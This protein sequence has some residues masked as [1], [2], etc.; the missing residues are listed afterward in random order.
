MVNR[1]STAG[2]LTVLAVIAAAVSTGDC[3]LLGSCPTEAGQTFCFSKSTLA[4]MAGDAG[5]APLD[6]GSVED[7]S[8]S[9]GGGTVACPSPSEIE[10]PPFSLLPKAESVTENVDECCYLYIHSTSCD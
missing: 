7:A 6:S 9:D 10:R 3:A 4:Q 2:I 1:A 5:A 8:T